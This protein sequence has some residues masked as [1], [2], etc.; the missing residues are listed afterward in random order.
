MYESYI[1]YYKLSFGLKKKLFGPSTK[2]LEPNL[3]FYVSGS[4]GFSIIQYYLG[5]NIVKLTTVTNSSNTSTICAH[6]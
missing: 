4:N 1:P 3:F 6:V 5:S 2:T